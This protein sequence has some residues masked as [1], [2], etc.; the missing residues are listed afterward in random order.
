MRRIAAPMVGGVLSSFFAV[1]LVSPALYLIWRSVGSR[2]AS[3]HDAEWIAPG[4]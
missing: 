2:R 1:L 3:K 4:P